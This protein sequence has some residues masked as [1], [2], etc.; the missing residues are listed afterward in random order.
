MPQGVSPAPGE[1]GATSPLAVGQGAVSSKKGTSSCEATRAWKAPG[2]SPCP[3]RP[4]EG[5]WCGTG[6]LSCKG[7]TRGPQTH[8]VT[9]TYSGGTA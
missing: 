5:S 2:P 6:R 3:P 4:V 9:L 7:N 1:L 8:S